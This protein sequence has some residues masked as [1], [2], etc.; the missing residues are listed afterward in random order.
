[1]GRVWLTG[2][3]SIRNNAEVAPVEGRLN[4]ML[5]MPVIDGGKLKA[6]VTFL[7]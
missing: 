1:L 6:V 4:S 2:V 7:F 5:A 3:P